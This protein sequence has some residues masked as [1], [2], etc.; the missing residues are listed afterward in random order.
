MSYLS[1]CLLLEYD[2]MQKASVRTDI[3]KIIPKEEK[4]N[5]IPFVLPF[6]P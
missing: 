3:T 1:C 4:D 2:K 6:L 5:G